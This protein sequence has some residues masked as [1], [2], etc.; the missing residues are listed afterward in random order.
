MFLVEPGVAQDSD[1]ASDG[2]SSEVEAKRPRK[3][4][5]KKQRS[6]FFPNWQPSEF[7]WHLGPVV[8]AKYFSYEDDKTGQKTS[9]VETEFGGQLLF[10]G[11]GLVSGN[12][13]VYLEPHLGLSWGQISS[14]TKT[15]DRNEESESV[16]YQ[17]SWAGVDT[18]FLWKF[19][20]HVLGISG[21]KKTFSD[22]AYRDVQSGELRNDFGVLILPWISQHYTNAIRRLAE[23][24]FDDPFLSE[25]DHWLHTR[26][27][28]RFFSAYFDLGP[29]VTYSKEYAKDP[30]DNYQQIASGRTDY[31]LALVGLRP[32][33]K[34]SMSGNAKYVYHSE[35]ELGFYARTKLPGQ[36]VNDAPVTT[37]PEDSLTISSFIGINNLFSGFGIG[38]WYINQ[39]LNLSE[40]NGKTRE[41]TEDNG[42]GITFQRLFRNDLSDGSFDNGK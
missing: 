7:S 28:T 40:K 17:R 3:R 8:G 42:F 10:E 20:R 34:L 23:D 1:Q 6:A 38:W 12:P 26:F 29:G 13:G 30:E 21:G 18:I 4:A 2:V 37:M 5:K 41:K 14:E 35:E 9:G 36:G 31:V 25:V 16:S 33:W 32:F 15:V 39:T 11:I 27:F 22:D 19:Y 24:S